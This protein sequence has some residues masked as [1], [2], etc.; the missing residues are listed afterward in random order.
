ML[1]LSTT[2]ATKT[3]DRLTGWIT[4]PFHDLLNSYSG[5]KGKSKRQSVSKNISAGI[6]FSLQSLHDGFLFHLRIQVFR[7]KLEALEIYNW[8]PR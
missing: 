7:S 1:N 6:T 4:H 8:H 3:A 5:F 2:A